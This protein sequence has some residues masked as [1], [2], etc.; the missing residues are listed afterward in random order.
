M[1]SIFFYIN[2]CFTSLRSGTDDFLSEFCQDNF[3]LNIKNL[4]FCRAFL[5]E[6]P[7]SLLYTVQSAF[8]FGFTNVTW[9][10]LQC[11]WHIFQ[12]FEINFLFIYFFSLSFHL[13]E[14]CWKGYLCSGFLVIWYFEHVTI[15]SNFT[16]SID[17]EG[18]Q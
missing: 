17:T 12:E 11:I 6:Q 15:L 7:A 16:I 9:E 13:F 5:L 18:V 10:R 1:F 4:L 14:K 8:D 3:I 2:I